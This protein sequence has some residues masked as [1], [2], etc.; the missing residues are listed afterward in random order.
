MGKTWVIDL[1]LGRWHD[2]QKAFHLF[3]RAQDVERTVR[4]VRRQDSAAGLTSTRPVCRFGFQIVLWKDAVY[5]EIGPFHPEMAQFSIGKHQN[6]C[7][8][9]PNILWFTTGIYFRK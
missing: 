4:T 9:R 2:Q 5:R 6:K 1:G 8:K 7:I 3:C